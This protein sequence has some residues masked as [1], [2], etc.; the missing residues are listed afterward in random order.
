MTATPAGSGRRWIKTETGSLIWSEARPDGDRVVV[1]MYRHRPMLDPLRHLATEYRV[2]REYR[3]LDL[4]HRSGI[5]CVEP[6]S[7]S[8][9][10]DRANGLHEILTTRE[11]AGAAPLAGLLQGGAGRAVPDLAPLFRLVRRMHER[12]VV[13]GALYPT[14]VL[15][16]GLPGGPPRFHLL[17]LAHGR[18]FSRGIVGTRPA[19]FDLLDLLCM[20]G[21][22]APLAGAAEWLAAYGQDDAAVRQLL[23][24]LEHHRIER[25][26]RHFRRIEVDARLT[27]DRIRRVATGT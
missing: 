22:R 8:H 5:A 16:A 4:L 26:W 24:R 15:V 9:G 10:R 14:N 27:F 17:D 13:H 1:K 19:D 3:I 21:R 12:G 20:T 7:W 2:E 18:V 11:I 6:L 23:A 25:P